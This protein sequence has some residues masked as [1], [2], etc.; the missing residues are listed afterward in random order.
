MTTKEA[1]AIVHE[2]LLAM[3]NAKSAAEAG[4]VAMEA[5]RDAYDRGFSDAQYEAFYEDD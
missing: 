5:L 2:M 1:E 4:T 3:A